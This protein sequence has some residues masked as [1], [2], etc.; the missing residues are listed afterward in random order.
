VEQ[1]GDLTKRSLTGA[2]AELATEIRACTDVGQHADAAELLKLGRDRGVFQLP[3]G[4]ELFEAIGQIKTADLDDDM[5]RIVQRCHIG[6]AQVVKRHEDV[7]VVADSLL[8]DPGIDLSI[9]ERANVEMAHA[10]ALIKTGSVGT[11]LRKMKQIA[12]N[13]EITA[14]TRAWAWRNISLSMNGRE[15]ADAA[16]HS[17]D[18]F[19]EVGQKFEAAIGLRGV[20]EASKR[21]DLKR[22]NAAYERLLQV[23]S[24]SNPLMRALR[25]TMLHEYA[26]FLMELRRYGDALEKAKEA[27]DV[28]RTLSGRTSELIACLHGAA[29]AASAA[30]DE[31]TAATFTSEANALAENSAV[32]P[33]HARVARLVSLLKSYSLEAAEALENDASA[34]DDSDVLAGLAIARAMSDKTLDD[35]KRLEI[36]ENQLAS[37]KSKLLAVPLLSAFGQLLERLG[38]E[39]EAASYFERAHEAAPLDSDVFARLINNLW[40]TE[41]WADAARHLKNQIDLVGKHPT[42][43]GAYGRSL[44]EE[45][46][47]W[48]AVGPL[49]EAH[50]ALPEG[51]SKTYLGGLLQLAIT[52]AS[53]ASGKPQKPETVNDDVTVEEITDAL[54]Q[55]AAFVSSAQRMGFWKADPKKGHTWCSSPEKFGQRLLHTYLAATFGSRVEI[56]DEVHAG[57]GRIDIYLLAQGGLRF[58]IELKMCG[59]GYSSTYAA[60]GE[61]Q[62]EHYMRNKGT[63]LGFLVVFD[64]RSTTNGE[65][66]LTDSTTA[67]IR[68]VLIDVCPTIEK[69]QSRR[70]TGTD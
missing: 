56:I 49:G 18:A 46:N 53:K 2:A 70:R 58:V 9:D 39:K 7:R 55:F 25:A 8:N 28:E 15:A 23:A 37:N 24:D 40:H 38:G 50:D 67:T 59:A 19:L 52:I 6:A 14:E 43:L 21:H 60:Q 51:D 36:V 4:M 48:E 63:S 33:H 13:P 29:F 54:S 16:E 17:V 27:V 69:R 34:A 30:G 5:R 10:I 66:L 41:R 64:G 11:G 20:I 22:T 62:I 3:I 65:K 61:D 1:L 45:G 68:E 35:A 57:A 12:R 26:Q 44:L 31:G 47:A 32:A 42:M